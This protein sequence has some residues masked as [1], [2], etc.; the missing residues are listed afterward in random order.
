L[1]ADAYQKISELITKHN[2]IVKILNYDFVN[3]QNKN[4]Y[5][6]KQKIFD[7]TTM[8]KMRDFFENNVSFDKAYI[9]N[10]NQCF[11][12]QQ[13]YFINEYLV[14]QIHTIAAA[15]KIYKLYKDNKVSIPQFSKDQNSLLLENIAHPAVMQNDNKN[16]FVANSFVVG[17]ANNK[18][19]LELKNHIIIG[20]IGSG[21]SIYEQSLIFNLHTS[22]YL[23][24]CFGSNPQCIIPQDLKV[25]FNMYPKYASIQNGC[26]MGTSQ[27]LMFDQDMNKINKQIKKNKPVFYISDEFLNASSIDSLMHNYNTKLLPTLLNNN[28]C[29][30]LISSHSKEFV[31]EYFPQFENKHVNQNTILIG[32]KKVFA[33][34]IKN[35]RYKIPQVGCLYMKIFKNKNN[36][37]YEFKHTYKVYDSFKDDFDQ[38]ENWWLFD[39][40]AAIQY[41]ENQIERMKSSKWHIE[42]EQNYKKVKF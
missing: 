15:I 33:S 20:P 14:A 36:K 1:L 25:I 21:K 30:S 22:K 27:H 35:D 11:K 3:K 34:V 16:N 32:G 19:N 7:D 42:D 37:K 13:E 4:Y 12:Q 17:H 6:L 40:D 18:N 10:N 2:E 5:Y 31:L 23:G 41:E 24:F 39:F 29:F 28:G 9:Y 38:E 26:S 8:Y